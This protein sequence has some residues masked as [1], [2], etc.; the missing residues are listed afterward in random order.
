MFATVHLMPVQ[1][2]E[3][4]LVPSEA[5]IQTGTRTVVIMASGDGNF[6]PA[7]IAI[8]ADVNGQTEVVKGLSAG[9]KVVASGQFLIDSE[10]SLRGT[11]QR[12]SGTATPAAE[13]AEPAK[14]PKA[15]T[16]RATG[17]VEQIAADE[18]TI[19]HGP[20]PDLK[21]GPMTMGFVP[22][23]AGMPKDVKVGDTVQFELQAMDDG[24]FRIVSI[25]HAPGASVGGGK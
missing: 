20:I 4:L 11:L 24:M 5:V 6:A 17:K 18:V 22:P 10:A 19:S 23:A 16:H 9:Q 7:E 14:P 2:R 15:T 12:L 13:P 8:G 21:W 1:A 3:T 25:A